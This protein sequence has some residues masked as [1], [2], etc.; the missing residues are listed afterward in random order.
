MRHSTEDDLILRYYGEHPRPAA[1]DE[2]LSHC[3][4]CSSLYR[5]IADTLQLVVA[6]EPPE[7]PESYPLD[8]WSQLRNRLPPPRAPWWRTVA[9]WNVL[10]AAAGVAIVIVMAAV[11][12]RTR[13]TPPTVSSTAAVLPIDAE[14]GERVRLAAIG[15]HLERSERVLLELVNAG[16]ERVDLSAEQTVAAELIDS[17]RL[18]RDTAAQSDDVLVAGVL[19]D[20]ERSFL[21]IVHGP[22]MPTSAELSA[23]RTRLDAPGLLFKV[24]VL[25]DELHERE[26]APVQPRKTT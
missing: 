10:S 15:D 14:A 7:R 22:S 9:S 23:V 24:R 6:A 18:Y 21:E 13:P 26:A 16:G 25:A 17:N 4:E 11:W 2:H 5:S 20:L 19:D 12:P 1:I 8:V 3:A